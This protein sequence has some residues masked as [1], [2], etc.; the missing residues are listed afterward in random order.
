MA[1]SSKAIKG[2]LCSTTSRGT[3]AARGWAPGLG[4]RTGAET[5]VTHALEPPSGIG[6]D[7]LLASAAMDRLLHHSHILVLDGQSYRTAKK[8]A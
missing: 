8:V 4:H 1:Q 7:G 6:H 3:M 2:L 5:V